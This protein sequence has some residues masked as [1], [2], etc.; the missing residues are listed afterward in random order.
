VSADP[1]GRVMVPAK[2]RDLCWTVFVIDPVAVPLT[3]AL[4][5][6]GW[7]T[8]DRLTAASAAT[9]G[10]AAACFATRRFRLGAGLYQASFLLDC[11][12]GKLAGLRGKQHG[13]GGWFDKA[14]DGA[15]IAVCSAGLATGLVRA[16]GAGPWRTALYVL[17]PNLRWVTA[18]LVGA[19]PREARRPGPAP[20]TRSELPASF[21]KV[22]R[23]APRRRYRPG[24][25][26]DTEAVAFTLGPLAGTPV[27]GLLVATA[28][29]GLHIASMLRGAVAAA[30]AAKAAATDAD[31]PAP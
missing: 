26:V 28:V 12:D 8:A 24:S 11:L 15:R 31:A 27:A 14:G 4:R 10:V 20:S 21:W 13:W 29:D 2:A 16:R 6:V 22:L 18:E 1:A 5:D 30:G 3:A 25:T 7:V 17:Y 19:R 9:A 23:A